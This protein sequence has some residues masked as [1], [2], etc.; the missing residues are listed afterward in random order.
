MSGDGSKPELARTTCLLNAAARGDAKAVGDLV[1][2]VY[3]ELRRLASV[4][5]GRERRDHTLQPTAL[6]H[7]AFARLID[8]TNLGPLDRSHFFAIAANVM[9][10]VLVESARA[11][12]AAKR[13]GGAKRLTIDAN[14]ADGEPAVD[15]S[16]LDGALARLAALDERQARVVE[17][18]FF[19]G[20][21]MEQ[22]A[23]VLGV[24]KRSAEADW[25][26]ARAWLHRELKR[27]GDSP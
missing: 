18:R 12:K 10:R 1:P 11:H 16:D 15:V 25:A 13:G 21:T 20:L 7:E 8:S 24:S 14:V 2:L 27:A 6:V 5:L 17:L 19:G 9:R 3:D 23:E 22:V 4:Y 26:M